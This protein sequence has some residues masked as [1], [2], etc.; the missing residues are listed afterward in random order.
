MKDH[1]SI[2]AAFLKKELR[3]SKLLFE[4]NMCTANEIRAEGHI[5]VTKL[6]L[7]S[8]P[9]FVTKVMLGSRKRGI[10]DS[11]AECGNKNV[12]EIKSS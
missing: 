7:L 6:S 11:P 8:Y 1:L 5:S 9:V 10:K 2:V 12:Q 4:M 3:L